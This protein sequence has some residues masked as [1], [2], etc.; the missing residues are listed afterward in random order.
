MRA[1]LEILLVF[2][3]PLLLVATLAISATRQ[4]HQRYDIFLARE[5][6]AVPRE[7]LEDVRRMLIADGKLDE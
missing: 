5:R 1:T 2:G 4:R 7:S 3:L 6:E